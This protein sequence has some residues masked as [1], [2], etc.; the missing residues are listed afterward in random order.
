MP[1]AASTPPLT[2][3]H[4]TTTVPSNRLGLIG[5][6]TTIRVLY[7]AVLAGVTVQRPLDVK[8]E[9]LVYAVAVPDRKNSHLFVADRYSD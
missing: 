2:L 8:G 4:S 5:R 6:Y 3:S 7:G 9:A 1:R